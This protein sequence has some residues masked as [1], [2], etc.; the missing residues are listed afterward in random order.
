MLQLFPSRTIAVEIFGFGVH[1]Y[2]LLYVF[3]FL[4][5]YALL[6]RLQHLRSLCLSQ[7]VWSH[8][9]TAAI[10]GVL[11]GGRFGYVLFYNPLFYFSQPLEIMAVWKGGMSSHGGF[12]GVGLALLLV[13]RRMKISLF[14]LLDL[15]VVP[16]AIGLALGRVGNL[17]NQELYG[18]VT[19]LPW[20][21]AIPGV[22]GMRHPVQMYAVGKD[23]LIASLCFLHLKQTQHLR[24]GGT[25]ALFLMLYALLRFSVEFFR[26]P[27]V[28]PLVLGLVTLT[29]GQLYSIPLFVV[30]ICVWWYVRRR[31]RGVGASSI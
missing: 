11:L 19:L 25:F 28:Q 23:L 7:D 10:L 9:L 21:I 1:W 14:T 24:P 30:G 13:A 16:A 15:I 3:A 5:G 26:Q 17:I 27:D 4:F 31:I 6:P 2:G 29:R 22:E 8:V 12:L 20:G 18:T